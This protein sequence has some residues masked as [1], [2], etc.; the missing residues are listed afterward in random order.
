MVVSLGVEDKHGHIGKDSR[1]CF[2]HQRKNKDALSPERKERL[3]ALKGWVW[4]ILEY[5]WEE[6]FKNLKAYADEH[7]HCRVSKRY[8]T[9]DG[10][11][12]GK[13]VVR[14]RGK[15]DTMSP[16]RRERLKGLKGW[17][18]SARK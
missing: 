15:K 8:K 3:E 10:Y 12:L 11:N 2:S 4:D 1:I 7:G 13:W 17:V 6:G 9:P 18:W 16:E 14:Q 5:Q